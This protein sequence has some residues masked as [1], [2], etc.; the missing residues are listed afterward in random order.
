MYIVSFTFICV[1]YTC[2]V[3]KLNYLCKIKDSGKKK[4]KK[5]GHG[6]PYLSQVSISLVHMYCCEVE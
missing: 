5:E 3:V 6:R 4:L 1:Y 2:I